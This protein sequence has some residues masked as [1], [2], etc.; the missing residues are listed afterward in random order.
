VCTV[1]WYA[2]SEQGGNEWPG[3]GGAGGEC[4][5]VHRYTMS[6]QGGNEWAGQGGG[7]QA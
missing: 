3:Q 4:V 6:T 2:M 1:H 5:R 7:C